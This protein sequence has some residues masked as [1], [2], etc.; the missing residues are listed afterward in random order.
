MNKRDFRILV[1][2]DDEIAL[3]VVSSLL[4]KEGYP[5]LTA[6]D[7]LEA[8]ATLRKEHISLVISDL[9][10]PGAD[11]IEV[12]RQ[13]MR[14]DPDMAV[15]I[16]TAYGTLDSALEAMEEGAF[17][18]LT[19]PFKVQEILIIAARAFKRAMLLDERKEL[20]RLLRDTYR[21]IEVI[22]NISISNN[23][24]VQFSWIERLERLRAMDVLTD[25]EAS[26]LKERLVKGE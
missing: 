9:R 1:A 15:V 21:D 18:Y 10:M 6:K 7:G 8:I 14:I 26:I 4:S 19:K 2:D 22:K 24:D 25:E 12:L 3:D 13:A 17:D 11:G 5:V 23:V 20:I 16:L